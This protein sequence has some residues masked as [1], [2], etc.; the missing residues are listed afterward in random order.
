MF[1]TPEQKGLSKEQIDVI[2]E[3][4]WK[5]VNEKAGDCHDCGVKPGQRHE[6]GCDC[7]RCT[8]C[9]WQRLSCDCKDGEPDIWTGLWAGQKECY[10]Q[11]LICYDDCKFFT[12]TEL[13]WCFD[14]NE[15]YSMKGNKK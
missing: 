6:E 3:K 7:A 9:G 10:E 14:L 5:E 13:G 12:G 2:C 8:S 4:L 11:K 15:W 1:F